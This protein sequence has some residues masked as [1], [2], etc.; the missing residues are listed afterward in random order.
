M[1]KINFSV[2]VESNQGK[3]KPYPSELT[4]AERRDIKRR[5]A[6]TSKAVTELEK[7]SN[8]KLAKTENDIKSELNARISVRVKIGSSITVLCKTLM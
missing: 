2:N 3:S 1:A 5:L 4:Q 7:L 6:D 8:T